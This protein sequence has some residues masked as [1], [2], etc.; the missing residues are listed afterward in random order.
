MTIFSCELY[1]SNG[2]EV[3]LVANTTQAGNDVS[4][5]HG[6]GG[7]YYFKITA[8]QPYSILV[9]EYY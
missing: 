5:E 3:D 6:P 1:D 9:E 8:M 4:Y 7:D 2:N